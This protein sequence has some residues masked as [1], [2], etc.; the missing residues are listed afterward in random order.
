MD[1]LK[2]NDDESFDLIEVK[3]TTSAKAEHVPDVAVRPGML[4]HRRH[5]KNGGLRQQMVLSVEVV[6]LRN[7]MR[8]G[9]S[10]WG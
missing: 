6:S 7:L 9:Q 5:N 3:S 4:S 1:I 2:R 10:R 8:V